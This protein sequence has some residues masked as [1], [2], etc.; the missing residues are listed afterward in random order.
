MNQLKDRISQIQEQSISACKQANSTEQLEAV[1]VEFLGRK[2]KIADLMPELKNLNNDE[3]RIIGPLINSLKEAAEQAY[4]EKK[5]AL[6]DLAFEQEEAQH[7][8]FDVTSYKPN[9]QYGSLHLYTQATQL[10][11]SIFS[12]MGYMIVD[13]PEIETEYYNFEALNIPKDHPARDMQD[14]FF[15]SLPEMVMRTHT[16]SVQIKTMQNTQPPFAMVCTGRTFRNEATDASHDFMFRQ[17]EGLVI[18]KDINLAQ[19]ISTM[20]LFLRKF[21]GKDDITVRARPGYFPF[22]EPGLE[23]DMSCPFCTDGCST[24]KHTRWI[25]LVGAGL[26]HPNVLKHGGIDAT[27][28]TGFAFGFGLTRLI[29]IKYAIKD[30]RL[31]HSAKIEFLQQF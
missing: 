12:S 15:L 5:L 24:C 7:K 6:Q 20:K 8:D 3:K 23:I 16:S 2:G 22:V 25:E 30:I 4:Q 18:G 31:L 11:Q 13:G 19:M 27:K 17:M 29:M 21:F 14:T 9:Q 1:R 26:V 28:Y 10:I